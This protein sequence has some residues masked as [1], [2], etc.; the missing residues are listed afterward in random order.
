[1][2]PDPHFLF[3]AAA[4]PPVLGIFVLIF[5]AAITLLKGR[6]TPANR[7]FAV[8]CLMGALNNTDLAALSLVADRGRL[9]SFERLIY[10]VFVFCLPVYVQFVHRLLGIPG[11][12]WLEFLAWIVGLDCC[13]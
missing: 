2:L 10:V 12:R 13:R 11:R 9:L 1:M 3:P 7:L 8:L 4:I 5:L 6:R